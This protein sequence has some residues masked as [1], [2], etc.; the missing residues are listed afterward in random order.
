MNIDLKAQPKVLWASA[1]ISIVVLFEVSYLFILTIESLAG[2]GLFVFIT[3]V[4][5]VAA[6]IFGLLM[7]NHQS[8]YK[9]VVQ[10][11]FLLLLS[12][13]SAFILFEGALKYLETENQ[14]QSSQ[15]GLSGNGLVMPEELKRN[16]VTVEGS[17][18]SYHWQ[19]VLHV[20]KYEG[21]RRTSE[22]P[23]KQKE[24]FRV[25]VLGDSLTYGYGIDAK[26]TYA[27]LIDAALSETYRIEVLNLG[28][29]GYQSEDILQIAKKYLPLLE[30]D[31]VIYG[32]CLN[33]FL[34]SGTGQ[35]QASLE[36]QVPFP[37]KS[38]FIERTTVGQFLSEKYN[39]LLI[40]FGLRN[41]FFADIMK[42]FSSYQSRFSQDV[43]S[44]SEFVQAQHKT[45]LLGMVLNQYPC[46]D[47]RS[48]E[49]T[50]IAEKHMAASGINVIPADYIKQ[51]ADKNIQ[52][53]VNQWE[54][55]PN[56]TAN[57]IFSEQLVSVI[58]DLPELR[59][60][61]R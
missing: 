46:L 38:V 59:S 42:D 27:S 30:P 51:Y 11:L 50:Q 48:Y 10:N 60:Y 28:V 15:N 19:G 53:Y 32:M 9:S 54:G 61:L 13:S 34:P 29:S 36:Y 6:G 26:S 47:C 12:L 43:H 58:S 5:A 40:N 44:L 8:K 55:H 1:I 2:I 33:D 31:L 3:F 24:V 49:I 45:T 14:T 57:R 18:R 56:E 17:E 25:I 20:H 16:P 21:F 7:K 41:D 4:L 39:A 22:F 23:A 52:L 35:Y 37:M